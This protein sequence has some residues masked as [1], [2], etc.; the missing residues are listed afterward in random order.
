MSIRQRAQIG[1][2][3]S[4]PNYIVREKFKSDSFC[5]CNRCGQHIWMNLSRI[6]KTDI[7]KSRIRFASRP[8]N[9]L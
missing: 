2:T 7:N 3:I 1:F 4:H 9:P 5:G 6:P 8:L